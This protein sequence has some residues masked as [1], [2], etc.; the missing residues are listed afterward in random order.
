MAPLLRAIQRQGPVSRVRTAVGDEA[1]LVTGYEQVRKLFGDERL[2]TRHPDPQ[3]APRAKV[4]ALY[5]GRPQAD[6]G[7]EAADRA[8]FRSLLQPFFAPRRIAALRPRVEELVTGLLDEVEAAPRPVDL[9]GM[10]ARPLP[11]AV[12]CELLGVPAGDRA[13]Y[14]AL[15]EAT[16]TVGDQRASA[17]GLSELFQVMR[18]LVAHKR[19]EPDDDVVS[20]LI[21]ATGGKADDMAIAGIAGVV[22]FAGHETT[23][24]QLGYATALLLS[25]RDQYDAI[26]ADPSLVPAAVEECLRASNAGGGGLPR[27]ARSDMEIAGVPIR[28][29]DLVLLD[30]RAANHDERIFADPDRFDIDRRGSGHLAFGHGPHY[31]VG[32]PLARLQMEIACRQL[33][34]RFPTMRLAVPLDALSVRQDQLTGGFG[35]LPTTW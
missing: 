1:W 20:G 32:A 14:H 22:M 24:A 10:L 19:V 29:G 33:V 8:R 7:N 9:I 12:I 28:A 6:S 34:R 4:T 35:E 16:A 11:I 30:N 17:S 3:R 26:L 5:G 18:E 2:G 15:T 31:C 13:R 27:Y 23:V 25:N 21:A